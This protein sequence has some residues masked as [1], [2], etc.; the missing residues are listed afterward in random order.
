MKQLQVLTDTKVVKNTNNN[1]V[2]ITLTQADDM[3]DCVLVDLNLDTFHHNINNTESTS[4]ELIELSKNNLTDFDMFINDKTG[5]LFISSEKSK[6]YSINSTGYLI[7][8]YR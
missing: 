4:G 6:N 3:P 7:Y 8:T 1:N 5:E 2:S